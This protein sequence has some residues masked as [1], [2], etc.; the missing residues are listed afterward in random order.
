MDDDSIKILFTR[1][2]GRTMNR[3]E[4]FYTAVSNQMSSEATSRRVSAG[5][6]TL[7]L[8]NPTARSNWG[9]ANDPRVGAD[10]TRGRMQKADSFALA[11][12][13]L[14]TAM[15]KEGTHSFNAIAQLYT[16]SPIV[17]PRGNQNWTQRQVQ[18]LVLRFMKLEKLKLEE[19][20]LEK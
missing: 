11:N 7:F 15:W 18:N 2:N 1:H 12:G 10:L 17:T 8:N 4:L 3:V 16:A 19:L 9:R 6:Q 5:I 20:E 14:A 13:S